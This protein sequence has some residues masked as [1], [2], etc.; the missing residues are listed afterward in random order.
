MN[1]NNTHKHTLLGIRVGLLVCLFIGL[2]TFAV[3]CQVIKHAFVWDDPAYGT[4]NYHIQ[5]GLTLRSISWS[6]TSL[7]AVNWHPLT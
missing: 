4:K 2:F 7:H 1:S 5:S 6:F 3:Y